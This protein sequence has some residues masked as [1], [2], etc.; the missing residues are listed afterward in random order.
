[1]TV[2]PIS[3]KLAVIGA[4]AIHDHGIE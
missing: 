1:M 4:E 2:I 3:A